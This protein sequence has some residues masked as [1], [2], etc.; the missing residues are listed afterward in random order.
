MQEFLASR[1]GDEAQA[2]RKLSLLSTLLSEKIHGLDDVASPYSNGDAESPAHRE[3]VD[4]SPVEDDV[5]SPLDQQHHRVMQGA[6]LRGCTTWAVCE[7]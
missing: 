4:V 2:K 3:S 1:I 5:A 7:S 6:R